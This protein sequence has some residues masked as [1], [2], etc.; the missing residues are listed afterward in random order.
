MIQETGI[1]KNA[2]QGHLDNPKVRMLVASL[3]SFR[4]KVGLLTSRIATALP[5][6]T[7]HDITHLDALWEVADTVVGDDFPL[8]P[9]EGY[10]FGGAVL[11]HDA[12]LCFEAYSGGLQGLRNTVEWRDAYARISGYTRNAQTV[13]AQADFETLRNL[14]ASQALKLAVQPWGDG[15]EAP[16][17]LIENDDLRDHYGHLIGKIASSHHWDIERVVQTFSTP[18]SP[19]AFL[20]GNWVV[21]SLKIACMLRVADAGHLDGA[22]AP[23]FLLKL[24]HL[25]SISKAHWG[26]QNRLGRVIVNPD[27]GTQ[28]IITSTKPFSQSES[29]AWWVAFDAIEVFDKELRNCNAVLGSGGS[30]RNFARHSVAGAGNVEELSKYVHTSNWEPV[31]AKVHVSDVAS[32]IQRLGGAE[33]YGTRDQL[34]FVLR[35]VIQNSSDAIMA[36]QIYDQGSFGKRIVV[37][38]SD[39]LQG[40]VVLQIDDDGIGMSQK[41]LAEDLIDFGKGFW[42]SQRAS[43]EFPGIH[44]G[45][46]DPAGRFGIGFF[47]VFMIANRVRVYSRRFD[48]G[49]DTVRCLSFENG[50]SLR[51]IL[52][53]QRPESFG[54]DFSTRV[55]IE[56]ER[57]FIPDPARMPIH[58][59]L[60]GHTDF[61]VMFSGYVAAVVA[62]IGF[63][64]VVDWNGKEVQVHGGFPP[65]KEERE[66]WLRSLSYVN[67]GVNAGAQSEIA[68][69]VHRL[70]EIR[71]GDKCYGLAAISSFLPRGA[72]FLSAKAVGGLVCP[73]GRFHE[74]FVG[75]IDHCPANAKREAGEMR[76]PRES[77][78]AWLKQQ[79]VMLKADDLN[80]LQYISASY[81]LCAFDYDPIN[82]LQAIL[83]TGDKGHELL[84]LNELPSFLNIGRRLGFRVS[85]LGSHLESFGQQTLSGFSTCT[86]LKGGKFNDAEVEEGVPRNPYSLIGVIHRSLDQRGL[87]PTWTT[88]PNAYDG[89]FGKCDCL[90]V[91]INR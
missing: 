3:E 43:E 15:T 4:D 59:A 55:E 52:S 42:R 78:E 25:N 60:H 19:A 30:H 28:L 38:L 1:W 73:H 31:D 71:D 40:R 76:A 33:L 41:T 81:S 83:V 75:L 14:H 20:Q 8:N 70:T 68:T 13:H 2:F 51:P 58:A 50:L 69:H 9:L 35:E 44:A 57:Q 5:E 80:P 34:Q 24:L 53:K 54:M 88:I 56:F 48:K 72:D 32:L 47:S 26:A 29:N 17:Y 21:D 10:I 18:R 77:I 11:L 61:F 7:I 46:Y 86:V 63:P 16:V 62:G 37:R 64:V 85:S 74:P 36:R 79:V 39:E 65:C 89:P 91:R 22:R 49:V 45:G 82:L 67:C 84:Y 90:E 66:E 6:L 23:S 87:I 27:D 12:A